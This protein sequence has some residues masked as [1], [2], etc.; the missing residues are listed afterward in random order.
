MSGLESFPLTSTVWLHQAEQEYL[1]I[2]RGGHSYR[3]NR[4]YESSSAA[5]QNV[6]CCLQHGYEGDWSPLVSIIKNGCLADFVTESVWRCVFQGL[7]PKP[8]LAVLGNTV[9]DMNDPKTVL[10]VIRAL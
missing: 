4:T 7:A 3:L 5:A 10:A 8:K 6:K 1:L 9:V 2:L